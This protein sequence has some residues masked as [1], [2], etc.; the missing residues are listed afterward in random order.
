MKLLVI[1]A[2]AAATLFAAL[3]AAA[4]VVVRGP[5]AA[6]VIGDGYRHYDRV[7]TMGGG[8]ITRNAG[9]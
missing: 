7:I 8:V 1:G 3:P 6:V 9:S 5:G 2:A 4:E